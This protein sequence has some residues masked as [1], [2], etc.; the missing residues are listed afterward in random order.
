M[1]LI[2]WRDDTSLPSRTASWPVW[3]LAMALV[4]VVMAAV[5]IAVAGPVS[6]GPMTFCRAHEA[7]EGIAD[8][9]RMD[10]PPIGSQVP[11]GWMPPPGARVHLVHTGDAPQGTVLD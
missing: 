10:V 2:D 11:A 3:T 5:F 6:D 8:L 4:A 1:A 7:R 9:E